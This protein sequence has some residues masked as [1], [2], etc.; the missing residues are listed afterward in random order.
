MKTQR[1]KRLVRAR[2]PP[3]SA[4]GGRVSTECS[5]RRCPSSCGDAA[6]PLFNRPCSPAMP[7]VRA[8]ARIILQS[9]ITRYVW[10]R[11][12]TWLGPYRPRCGSVTPCRTGSVSHTRRHDKD[13]S[14]IA[15]SGVRIGR[16]VSRGAPLRSPGSLPLHRYQRAPVSGSQ[17][18]IAIQCDS[19]LNAG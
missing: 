3:R 14:V 5:Q 10:E 4:S 7:L 11:N 13:V 8:C 6:S 1:R 19:G 15:W 18:V 9:Q 2:A 12:T 16:S 17:K